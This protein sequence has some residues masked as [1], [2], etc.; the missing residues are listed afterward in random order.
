M[1]SGG[2]DGGST[3]LN[4]DEASDLPGLALLSLFGRKK[5]TV[6]LVDASS[7]GLP[8]GGQTGRIDFF[9]KW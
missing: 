1:E 6:L 7:R 8:P 9:G 5:E 4:S 3:V 2:S